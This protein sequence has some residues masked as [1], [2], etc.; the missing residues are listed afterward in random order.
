[1][2]RAGSLDRRVTIQRRTITQSS[3]GE[4]GETWANVS[5]RRPAS[6]WPL[7]GD[8]ESFRSPEKVAYE[9]IEFRVRYSDDVAD[10]SPLDRVIHPA[11]T[12][13]QAADPNYVIPTRS[14]FD[15]LGTLEIDRRRGIRII[16]QRRADVTT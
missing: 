7:K 14:I 6:M 16:T 1:M 4:A 11:L 13:A 15:V 5:V 2:I 3:S 9:R 8:D 10:L 12:T